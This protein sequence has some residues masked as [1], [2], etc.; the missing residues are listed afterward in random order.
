MCLPGGPK[1]GFN[2]STRASLKSSLNLRNLSNSSYQL[3]FRFLHFFSICTV[4]PF[5]ASSLL[6][7]LT[8]PTPFDFQRHSTHPGGGNLLGTARRQQ[9]VS[10]HSSISTKAGPSLHF[11]CDVVFMGSHCFSNPTFWPYKYPSPPAP[12]PSSSRSVSSSSLS[13]CLCNMSLR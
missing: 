12:P 10:C 3:V 9:F 13:L 2:S 8:P 5:P 1:M 6:P 11:H 4:G 7:H